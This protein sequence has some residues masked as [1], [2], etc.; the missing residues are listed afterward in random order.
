M[1]TFVAFLLGKVVLSCVLV[2]YWYMLI[3]HIKENTMSNGKITVESLRKRGC[4]IR[5]HHHRRKA[6]CGAINPLG[7]KTVV[8]ITTPD[9]T[10]LVGVSRCSRKENFN[11]RLGVRIALGRA[12]A[13][14]K[15]KV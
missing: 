1:Q 5:V 15:A 2:G 6:G 8:E 13:R 7:G 4:K 11:K 10:T 3:D 9:G 12:M 14:R